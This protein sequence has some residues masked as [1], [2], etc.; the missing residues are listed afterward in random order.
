MTRDNVELARRLWSGIVENAALGEAA[1]AFPDPAW[2]PEVEYV[3][4]PRWP[5]SGSYR[6]IEAVTARFAEYLEILGAVEIDVDDVRGVTDDTV[7]SIW[8]SRGRTATGFPYE[9]E[10]AWLWTFRDGQ[11]VRWQAFLDKEA[12]LEAARAP[13]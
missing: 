4:D 13:E 5:G 2:Y 10:W 3:E 12:A 11:V 9:Q 8:R 1:N 6:G 7:I